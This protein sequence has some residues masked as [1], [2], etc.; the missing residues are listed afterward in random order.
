[1]I[2]IEAV[3][4]LLKKHQKTRPVLACINYTHDKIQ[5]TNS[6]SM[7]EIEV[8][9]QQPMLYNP[10]T[11]YQMDP[12][13]QYPSLDRIKPQPEQLQVVDSIKIEVLTYQD[14][15]ELFYNVDGIYFN[16]ELT[17][18]TF[19]TVNLDL[20]KDVNK[21]Y[22]LQLKNNGKTGI[23]VYKKHNIYI[24]ILSIRNEGKNNE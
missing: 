9:R 18:T 7:V 5:Y 11:G 23:L 10:F 22:H 14:K 13:Q 4:K 2:K 21:G 1:M 8:S 15:T 17:D 24:L 19:K 3:K 20:L 6:Y 16:K 12:L